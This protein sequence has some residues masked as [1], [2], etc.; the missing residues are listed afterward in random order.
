[1]DKFDLKKYLTESKLTKENKGSYLMSSD[2]KINSKIEEIINYLN[3]IDIDGETME[4]ILT[5]VGLD[6]QMLSQLSN[7]K[8]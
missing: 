3:S 8:L 5:R 4:Y 2:K 7:K 6:D 1:M